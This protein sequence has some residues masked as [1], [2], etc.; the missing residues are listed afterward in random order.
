MS[1][2][3]WLQVRGHGRAKRSLLVALRNDKDFGER[4][5]INVLAGRTR[6]ID[7]N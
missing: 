7:G 1:A 5:A 3:P 2:E 6:L 4:S